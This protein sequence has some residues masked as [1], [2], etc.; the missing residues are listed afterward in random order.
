MPD[1]GFPQVGPDGFTI[2]QPVLDPDEPLPYHSGLRGPIL[3]VSESVSRVR[4]R[5]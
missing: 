2:Y 5:P 4:C 3:L 1:A